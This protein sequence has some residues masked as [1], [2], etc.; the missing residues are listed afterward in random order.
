MSYVENVNYIGAQDKVDGAVDQI[1][2]SEELDDLAKQII[3][4]YLQESCDVFFLKE[5]KTKARVVDLLS[6]MAG[7]YK[8]IQTAK[9]RPVFIVQDNHSWENCSGFYFFIGTYQEIR[10]KLLELSQD[11]HKLRKNSYYY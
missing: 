6:G 3:A 1:N 5:S 11:S 8:L 7:A 4:S 10:Q 2:R 9:G